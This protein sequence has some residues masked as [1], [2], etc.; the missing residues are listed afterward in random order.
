MTKRAYS[1]L[2][3]REREIMDVVYRLGEA[4]VSEVVGLID[5]DPGY[6]SVRIT[7]GI[8]T[9]KGHLQHR[10]EDRRYIYSPTVPH[11]QASRSAFLSLLRTFF[12]GSPKKAILAMLDMSSSKLTQKDVDEITAWLDRE[13]KS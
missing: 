5:G 12:G 13:K 4:N 3:R 10:R 2:S 6:D 1:T 11:G 7:L 8:L 9:K